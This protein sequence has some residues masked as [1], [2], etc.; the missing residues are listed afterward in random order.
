MKIRAPA[1][2]EGCAGVRGS[3][4]SSTHDQIACRAAD[5]EGYDDEGY[6]APCCFL[7]SVHSSGAG[8]SRSPGG[9]V[10]S[11]SL[12]L[13]QDPLPCRSTGRMSIPC[14][15]QPL[16]V[17][18]LGR[19]DDQLFFAADRAAQVKEDVLLAVLGH[20]PQRNAELG[21]G[22]RPNL[23]GNVL[24]SEHL[25]QGHLPLVAFACLGTRDPCGL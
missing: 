16:L 6:L 4:P 23:L 18:L 1:G 17:G 20:R 25:D 11:T 2:R 14:P 22:E 3:T 5:D 10:R 12:S 8:F 13:I 9:E 15:G 7:E 24:G 19:L 21:K